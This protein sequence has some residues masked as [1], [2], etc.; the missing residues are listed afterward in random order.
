M[1]KLMSKRKGM[2]MLEKKK[3]SR[4]MSK[5]LKRIKNKKFKFLI[6]QRKSMMNRKSLMNSSW[7]K[8]KFKKKKNRLK[9]QKRLICLR[10]SI[11]RIHLRMKFKKSVGRKFWKSLKTKLRSILRNLQSLSKLR[12]RLLVLKRNSL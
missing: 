11:I 4:K 2:K 9:S 7:K 12:Q 8:T 3:F 10:S 6:I 1:S 5:K